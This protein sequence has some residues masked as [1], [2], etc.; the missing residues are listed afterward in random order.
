MPQV[1]NASRN[2]LAGTDKVISMAVL[3]S[4]ATGLAEM[5]LNTIRRTLEKG[6]TLVEL[7]IVVII[8]AILAAIVVPQFASSTEDAG[9]SSLDTSL[10]NMRAAIDLYRHQHGEYPGLNTAVATACPNA[11]TAGTGTGATT[12]SVT[13]FDQMAMY[14]DTDGKACSTTDATFKFGPYLKK[15]NF[16]ANPITAD[17]TVAIVSTGNLVM[18]GANPAGGWKFDLLTGRFIADDAFN[19]D[20]NGDTYDTH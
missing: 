11:G 3:S 4:V 20:A 2:K 10:N 6:F 7:L 9:V 18:A 14:T 8:L 17:N 19:V 1:S 16:Q 15:R 13:F 12:D 5:K